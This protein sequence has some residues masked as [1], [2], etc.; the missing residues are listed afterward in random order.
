MV[1][2]QSPGGQTTSTISLRSGVSAVEIAIYTG[3]VILLIIFV[4]ALVRA[5]RRKKLLEKYGD[6]EVVDRIMRKRIWQGMSREQLIDSWGSPA[7]IDQKVYKEKTRDT[8]KYNQTGRNRYRSR[9]T[10]EN[11]IVVGWDLK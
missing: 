2:V 4:R 8:Y 1:C 3:L 11:G 9:V 7:D 5:A 10:V 6:Q